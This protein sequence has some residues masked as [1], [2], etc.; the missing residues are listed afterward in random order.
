MQN[1]RYTSCAPVN[2]NLSLVKENEHAMDQ[3]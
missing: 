2:R 3:E 1:P